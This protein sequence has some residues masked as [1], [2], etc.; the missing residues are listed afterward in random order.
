MPDPSP[1]LDR[2]V[3]GSVAVVVFVVGLFLAM[4][5]GREHEEDS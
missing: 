1:F 3:M 4:W 5:I 2:D